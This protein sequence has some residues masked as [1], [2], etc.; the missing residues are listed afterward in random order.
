MWDI[1]R[2]TVDFYAPYIHVLVLRHWQQG[3]T[4]FIDIKVYLFNQIDCSSFFLLRMVSASIFLK[5]LIHALT[6]TAA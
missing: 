4:I 1:Y 6:A 5:Q 3:D 2:L